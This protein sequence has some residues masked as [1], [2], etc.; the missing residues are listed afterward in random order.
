MNVVGLDIGGANLKLG[1]GKRFAEQRSFPLWKRPQELARQLASM[2]AGAP[3]Y[4]AIAVTMT[5]ELADCFLTKRQG[6][7]AIL[8]AVQEATDAAVY[9]YATNGLFVS[10]QTAR[11][12][13]LRVAAANWHALANFVRRFLQQPALLI[14]VGSTTTDVI[15][16]DVDHVRA[17]GRTDYERL[18]F[19]ELVYTGVVRSPVAGLVSQLNLGGATCPVMNELFATTADVYALLGNLT[20]DEQFLETADGRALTASFCRARLARMI[21]RDMESL[22]DEEA[23]SLAHQ[24]KRAQ[25]RRILKAV[26]FVAS[27]IDSSSLCLV[28]S[29]Q[30]EFVVREVAG[31]Y[32]SQMRVPADVISLAEL[33][34]EN[35][36]QTATA[37][38]VAA[39]LR[40][41]FVKSTPSQMSIIE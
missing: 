36:C 5:G 10:P 11:K 22:S 16:V 3:S 14:D 9:V 39:L 35:I 15:P 25:L 23:R 29:G 2:L 4:E 37:H 6:V 40:E 21:G 12:Q 19:R 32:S 34:G 30:G 27:G 13:F 33:L 26:Q 38:A 18:V 28:A 20:Y 8:D 7:S 24:I 31:I 17:R 1:D 41:Q